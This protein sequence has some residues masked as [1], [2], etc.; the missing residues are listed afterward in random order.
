MRHFVLLVG[1]FFIALIGIND[2]IN[3]QNQSNQ[4]YDIP[5]HLIKY[6]PNQVYW[7]IGAGT[8]TPIFDGGN[9]TRPSQLDKISGLSEIIT[10]FRVTRIEKSFKYWK[11][12]DQIGRTY[13]ISF[14]DN[15]D[16]ADLLKDLNG[17]SVTSLS[18]LIPFI[19]TF[20]APSDPLYV[21]QT[22]LTQVNAEGAWGINDCGT[23]DIVIAIVDD[24]VRTSHED[25]SSKIMGGYDVADNDLNPNPPLS[26]GNPYFS[27]G[28]HVAGIAAAVT[29]NAIGIASMGYNCLIMPIKTKKDD[30]T[31]SGGLDNPY[32]GVCY[33]IMNGADVINMSWGSYGASS[34]HSDI[35]LEAYNAG[36]VCVAAAGNSNVFGAAFPARYPYVIGVGAVD[37]NN[38]KANFSNYGL[39]VDIMAPGVQILSTIATGNAD[40]AETFFMVERRSLGVELLWQVHWLQV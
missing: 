38:E 30:N 27:H 17:L 5:E 4:Q 7:Q 36:I 2:S 15:E 20:Q 34:I 35:M 37:N 24:A 1:L 23:T 8:P 28:T 12:E 16:A 25:L 26:V 11:K 32:A 9:D 40:Y 14:E 13:T 10:N 39:G 21:N 18:E 22:Y 6:V 33:A 31:T 29:N 19:E 3:A